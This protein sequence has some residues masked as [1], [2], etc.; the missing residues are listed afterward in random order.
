[1]ASARSA[2]TRASL[3]LLAVTMVWGST[4]VLNQQVIDRITVTDL[5]TWRFGIAAALMIVLRPH[6]LIQAPRIHYVHGF[7]LGCALS[8]GYLVQLY[9]LKHTSATASG[10]ITGLFVVFVPLISGVV[11]RQRIPGAA[12][13]GT[14]M[15]AAG[16]GLI[17]FNGLTFGIGELLTLLCA[18]MFALHIIGLDKWADPEYVYSLTTT[19]LA[20]VFLTSLIASLV[21]G[22]IAT[23]TGASTWGAIVFLAV[24]ATCIGYFA[25]TWVQSQLSATRAA[26]ILTMEPVFAGIF[27]VTLGT[28]KLTTRIVLGAALILAATYVVELGPRQSVEALRPHLEP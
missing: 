25:Q 19:Q 1:M 21:S 5:Q 3:L 10:F 26:V 12:W 7:W 17:A 16:L 27:G 28:D 14:A 23:P 6:W 2:Q 4:F 20:T 9:G 15:A 8:A 18:I 11:L 22:H 13:A 24:A